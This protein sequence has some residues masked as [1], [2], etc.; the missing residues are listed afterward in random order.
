MRFSNPLI[1]GLLVA[2][3]LFLDLGC[4]PPATV[5]TPPTAATVRSEDGVVMVSLTANTARAGQ[6]DS[7]LVRRGEGAG[8]SSETFLLLQVGAGLS[9]DTSIFVGALPPGDYTFIRLNTGQQFV[10][11]GASTQESIGHFKVES[12]E[13]I[14]LGRLILTGLNTHVLVGR[15]G[16]ATD[17]ADL[18][19]ATAPEQAVF[20]DRKHGGGWVGPRAKDDLIEAYAQAN[21]VGA[22]S[23]TELQGEFVV[24]CSRMGMLLVRKP[25]GQ[26]S[27]LP[28]GSLASLLSLAPVDTPT[29]RLVAV[30]EFRSLYRVGR[31][32]RVTPIDPGN[33][34]KGNL[35]FIDG[36]DQKGWIL[37]HQAGSTLTFYQSARLE[38]GDWKPFH[39][40]TVKNS[41]WSGKNG[42]WAWHTAA[43]F[44][45]ATGFGGMQLYDR[46]KSAFTKVA[47]PGDP[48]ILGLS[49]QD[50]WG[51]LASPGGGFGGIFST[52]YTSEDQGQTWVEMNSP[53]KAKLQPPCLMP[54]GAILQ[55]GGITKPELQLSQDGG[56][57]WA[58]VSDRVRTSEQL[59]WTPHCGVFA[60][61]TGSASFGFA[62]ISNS[63]DLGK[64]WRME[65]TN[66]NRAAYEREH[67]AK[68]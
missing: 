16:H 19:R 66:F 31:D 27:V 10:S 14:D 44:G 32:W 24:A 20:L 50:R 29:A 18:L 37:G 67:P 38:A 41:I 3:L 6:F 49:I 61:E 35:F 5:V 65:I 28:T 59:V 21:P 62:S 40:E 54:G 1:T 30:G 23:L 26:W 64:T 9:R 39:Q 2:G 7:L 55:Q 46:S 52:I 8:Q 43:G 60:I 4:V 25:T 48:N 11:L 42:I 36:D 68:P 34:P 45:Y 53:F 22:D 58:P 17:N 47:L 57:T 56:R 12:G 33:L 63:Q 15:S 51:L 13:T